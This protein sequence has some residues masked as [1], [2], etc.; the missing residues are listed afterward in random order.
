MEDKKWPLFSGCVLDERGETAWK[1][2]KV[3]EELVTIE[4]AGGVRR[5]GESGA[6]IR[7]KK[8]EGA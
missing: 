7:G 5:A 2:R 4:Q 1:K 8:H 6:G 3:D